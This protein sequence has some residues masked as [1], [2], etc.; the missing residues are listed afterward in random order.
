M[1]H[2]RH[3]LVVP[4]RP[5]SA[6]GTPMYLYQLYRKKLG[7][8]QKIANKPQAQELVY[9]SR[10]VERVMQQVRSFSHSP[11][12]VLVNGESG[13]GKE[14]IARAIHRNSPY[15]AGQF[16]AL[17]CSAIPTEL[18]EGELF[19]HHDGAFTGSRRGGRKGL[20]EEAQNGVLFLDEISELALDQQAK[21]LRFLQERRFRPLGSNQE[22]PVDLKLVAATNKP[23]RDLV[24]KGQF[25]QD[26][27]FR[28]N[29]FN[30]H[31]PPLRA[32]REDIGSLPGFNWRNSAMPTSWTPA[33]INCWTLFAPR[34]PTMP[35]LA[36]SGSWKTSSSGSWLA[37][38][39]RRISRIWRRH[40]GTS[41]LN[42]SSRRTW[43]GNKVYYAIKSWRW[44]WTP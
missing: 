44:W 20:V 14:L 32:R 3:R 12:N 15:S 11:S 10:A 33:P 39:C 18:F 8:E 36:M 41:P 6:F 37:N 31:I 16:V 40:C 34:S 7:G 30:I 5:C 1:P 35:G 2:K 13:T 26:L 42:C 9:Q 24:E 22:K 28:L 29:V 21:L 17:N 25:R 38:R 19:G 23:L 27:Y 4:S 43:T